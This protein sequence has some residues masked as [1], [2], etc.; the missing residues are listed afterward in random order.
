[1]YRIGIDVGGTFTDLVAVDPEG[2]ATLAKSTTTP[3]DPA[4]GVLEGLNRLA[5][6][7]GYDRP[8]LLRETER[9]VHGTTVATNALLERKGAKVGLLT[10]AGHRDVLEM[11]EGLKDDRYNLR[12]PP[13]VPLVPRIRRL[14]VKERVR[15]DGRVETPLD[16]KSLDRAI[17]QL[18][19][20]GVDAV[21]VCYFHAYRN[22]RHEKATASALKRAFKG[23]YVSLSHEVYPQIK[24]FQRVSTT[25]VNAY[26]G[27][28]LARYLGR[29]QDRLR[30]AGYGGPVLIIQSHGGVAPIGE[31][32]R[33]AAGSVLSGP[34]GGV[35]GSR[36]AAR[37]LNSPDLIPFDMGGT[38]TDICLI[39]DGEPSLAADRGV[40]GNRIALNSLAIESLGAGG[41]SIGRVDAGG[42]LH[43]GPE[44]A[45]AEP[46]PACYGK[47]GTAA[48]VT[49]ANLVLGYLDPANF[50]GGRTTLDAGAAEAAL[51]RLAGDLG[52]TR[53]AAAEGVHRVV[54]TNMAE[55]IRIVSVRRGVD[56]RR[57]A[58]LAFG[59][60]AG[61]HVTDVAR[62]LDLGRVVVPR[63]AAVLSAWGMLATDLRYEVSRTHIG[64]T[65]RLNGATVKKLFA[66]MEAEGRAR[67][68]ASFDGPIRVQRSAEMRYGEQV[69]EITV[70]LDGVDWSAADPLPAI[71][72]E[73]H[74]RHEELY[75]YALKDQDAVLVNARVAVIGLLPDLPQEPALT[76]REPA[77]PTAE[78]R[79]YL[80]G[81]LTA[82]VYD[83]DRLAP[84][85]AIAGPAIIESAMTTVLL[86]PGN[87]AVVTP[88]GWLDINVPLRGA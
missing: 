44:S 59:G 15:A 77:G 71:A 11:R 43:V 57:F 20:Q 75:T 50:L 7:L 54:N 12:M 42:I 68:Q 83:L 41:G 34:A 4:I 51:D 78:R 82:P 18:A 21:A 6:A 40:G 2:R 26:V 48:T 58:L 66:D 5:E 22:P 10:T 13:P 37:L 36:Y 17:A 16:P 1:M 3:A 39:V 67:L 76:V 9:I 33:L 46:G 62:Q 74:R 86:R 85:Q 60:A 73:F 87:R 14:G 32:S 81:W 8:G 80:G 45:G 52:V 53:L 65:G 38:S 25:V 56:P 84:A 28:I 72:G 29:L 19:R 69:F 31:A 30:E 35:A 79:I 88:H 24:E 47:G 64:D 63:V 23:A 27:P 70:P 49:D 55:G 61:L